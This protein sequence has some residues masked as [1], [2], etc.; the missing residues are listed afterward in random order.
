MLDTEEVQSMPH[1]DRYVP[2]TGSRVYLDNGRAGAHK[3][4]TCNLIMAFCE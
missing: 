2:S 1:V 3:S 4:G